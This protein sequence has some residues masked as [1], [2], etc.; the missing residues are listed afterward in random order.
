[1]SA[2]VDDLAGPAVRQRSVRYLLTDWSGEVVRM[3]AAP[4]RQA[5]G[6]SVPHAVDA[7]A[8]LTSARVRLHLDEAPRGDARWTQSAMA[9]SAFVRGGAWMPEGVAAWI[10]HEDMHDALAALAA[11][12][13]GEARAAS[14]PALTTRWRAQWAKVE[15][16]FLDA[17]S[18]RDRPALWAL[19]GSIGRTHAMASRVAAAGA[20][21]GV[22]VEGGR[23]V[24]YRAD[25]I[26]LRPL[27]D[28]YDLVVTPDGTATATRIIDDRERQRP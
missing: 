18:R 8:L 26:R 14:M 21:Q 20:L 27:A 25:V 13:A 12:L 15:G 16:K 3:I 6:M 5:R 4:V 23:V 7:L 9:A 28:T 17:R 2:A 1:M 11:G 10:G 22:L 19:P 24:V